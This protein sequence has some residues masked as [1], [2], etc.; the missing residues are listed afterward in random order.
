MI[1]TPSAQLI[2]LHVQ[3]YNLQILVEYI[4]ILLYT[5][6]TWKS[7]KNSKAH[8]ITN[9][10]QT[11]LY[12]DNTTP[13]NPGVESLSVRMIILYVRSLEACHSL[14]ICSTVQLLIYVNK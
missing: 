4:I 9:S 8:R 11:Y 14:A 10:T 5:H 3:L 7:G 12:F 13:I 6:N 1:T 2:Y